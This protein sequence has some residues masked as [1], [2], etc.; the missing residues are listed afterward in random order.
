MAFLKVI[1]Q[2]V[3]TREEI[4]S[5]RKAVDII[6]QLDIEDTDGEYFCEIENRV[7]NC[8]WRY[9]ANILEEI[10]ADCDFFD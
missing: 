7:E 1:R 9:V 2:A 5:L 6:R 10:V 4:D 8:E 3:L